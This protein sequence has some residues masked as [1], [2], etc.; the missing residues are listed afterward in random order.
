MTAADAMLPLLDGLGVDGQLI[1]L[2][3]AVDPLP[4]QTLHLLGGRHSI[5]GW[6]SGTCVDSEDAMK[7][8]VLTGV[9]P[10]IETM[11]LERA[12]DAYDRMASG[13]ARFR[14]VLTTA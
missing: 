14:M 1:V 2:G 13:K 6:P 8:A 5:K 7:F 4:V 9:R 11:P 3:A 10:F 12:Q